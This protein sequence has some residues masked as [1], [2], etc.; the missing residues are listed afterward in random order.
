MTF[1]SVTFGADNRT[2][3]SNDHDH[4]NRGVMNPNALSD[5]QK[6][7]VNIATRTGEL[8]TFNSH[9]GATTI[10]PKVTQVQMLERTS[11]IMVA[12]HSVTEE[13]AATLAETAPNLVTRV[14]GVDGKDEYLTVDPAV[15]AAEAAKAETEAQQAEADRVDINTHPVPEIEAA[16]MHLNDMVSMQDKIALMVAGARGE[17]P[18]PALINR[19]AEQMHLP[20]D[21]AIEAINLVSAGTSAQFTALANSMNLDAGRAQAWIKEHRGDTGMVSAQA[22]LMRRDVKAWKPLLE[23]YRRAT[24][25]GVAH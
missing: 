25:D 8:H 22:H 18:S 24:G 12:G 23:D 1:Q 10:T 11:R 15:K 16:H 4:L 3:I 6:A 13:V 20:L 17:T 7:N 5:A 9:S 14:R 21:K 2:V 19:I